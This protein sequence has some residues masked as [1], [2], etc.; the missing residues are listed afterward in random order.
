MTAEFEELA[1][2]ARTTAQEAADLIVQMRVESV[3][4]AGTKSSA[5]DVVTRA[6]LAAEDLIRRRLLTARPDDG[7]LGE[8]GD[9]I[10]SR[11]G[12][13]WVV[14][15]IDGTVNYL[16]GIPYYAVSIAAQI[17]QNSVVGVVNAP[18][19]GQEF[20]A[21]RGAGAWLNGVRIHTPPPPP[22]S[23]ALVATGFGYEA[24]IRDV[25]AKATALLLPQVRDIRR[26]GSCAIDLCAVASGALDAYVES[27]P[28]LWD[29][30]AGSLIAE[31]AGA[32]FT[33]VPSVMEGR[34]VLLCASR[35]RFTEFADVALAC[36][37]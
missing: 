26:L 10:P 15:P 35:E 21:M 29:Y 13:S 17:E 6:D 7:F 14:D 23:A 16:Y 20:V 5:T 22:L 31:E 25:Q 1:S 12:V 18:A 30:A 27:G 33:A 24:R 28:N 32:Q 36:G 34:A 8:E 2:L 11:S 4:I 19:L 3:E 37:Y 9:D